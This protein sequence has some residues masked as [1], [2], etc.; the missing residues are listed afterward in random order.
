MHVKNILFHLRNALMILIINR[1]MLELEIDELIIV[2]LSE[3]EYIYCYNN[4]YKTP[5]PSYRYGLVDG[6]GM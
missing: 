5:D 3:I 4:I 2:K 1:F 6:E